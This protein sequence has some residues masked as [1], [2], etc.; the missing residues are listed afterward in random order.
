MLMPDNKKN[1]SNLSL[2]MLS[3]ILSVFG[4]TVFHSM[5][6]VWVFFTPNLKFAGGSIGLLVFMLV[7]IC[8]ITAL[9]FVSAYKPDSISDK[10]PC[11]III[12]V[13]F[14][15]S[16]LIAAAMLAVIVFAGRETG[17]VLEMYL[18]RD[19]FYPGIFSLVVLLITVFP[20]L[21]LKKMA[22]VA[23]VGIISFSLL[24]FKKA[25]PVFPFCITSNP[26]VF[27]TGEDYS[28]VFASNY[29]G[30]AYVEYKY[31][32][33]DYKVYAQ[34]NGRRITDRNIH[35][36]N[37]PYEHLKNNNYTV[38]STMVIGDYSYG[39]RLGKT[40]KKGPYSFN[41]PEEEKQ[42]YLVVSD[43]HTYL[44]QAYSAISNI[45]DYD[46]ILFMGDPAPG[47]DFEEEAV[48]YIVEFGGRISG[49]KMPI[50]YVRGNH[51]TRGSFAPY[52][53]DYLGYDKFYYTVDRGE[54]SF[55]VLDSGEDKE[56]AHIEYGSLDDYAV[57]RVQMTEWLESIKL[58]N[59]KVIALS[60]AW[61]VS[62]PEPDLSYRAF[63]LFARLG[64]RFEIS[65]HTHECR[66]RD[67]AND[68]EKDYLQ[69]Y[70]GITTYIDGG[71]SGKNYIASV[72]T[73]DKDGVLFE[74]YDNTGNKVMNKKLNW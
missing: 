57:S 32:G 31:E 34:N 67:G 4:A 41:S 56:D 11:S 55:I 33:M 27:D 53:A 36:V 3:F 58:N 22:A 14:V 69:K 38:G 42:K 29:P 70:P 64:V 74:A 49:G 46:A 44:K 15:I 62:E 35:S 59:N 26:C 39:S 61:Q 40:V 9:L 43:W 12:R 24:C 18:R 52:L 6:F 65:G 2:L 10:K 72:I 37:I 54:Y 63:D 51:E 48:K 21:P 8:A 45:K 50:I 13:L 16:V 17:T 30:T 7:I 28:V 5:R 1:T 23:L 60:H 71:I 68:Q 20:L 73:L 47:M 66:F 25:F 19:I